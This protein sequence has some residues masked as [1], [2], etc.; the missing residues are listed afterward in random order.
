MGITI[1]DAGVVP[2]LDNQQ[3]RPLSAVQRRGPAQRRRD[4]RDRRRRPTAGDQAYVTSGGAITNLDQQH[5][6]PREVR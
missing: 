5:A 6:H 4:L 3:C 1:A 2:S